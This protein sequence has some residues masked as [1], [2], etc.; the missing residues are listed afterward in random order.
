MSA[1][2]N[3]VGYEFPSDLLDKY[4]EIIHGHDEWTM[5]HDGHG[6]VI[7]TFWSQKDEGVD[8]EELWFNLSW[9]IYLSC[10]CRS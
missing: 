9:R 10:Q 7:I 2:D 1:I 3:I 4:S 5:D 6:N 8:D